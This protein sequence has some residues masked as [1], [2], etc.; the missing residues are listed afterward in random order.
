[1]SLVTPAALVRT[2]KELKDTIEAFRTLPGVTR[3]QIDVVDGRFAS[4]ASWPYT[5]PGEIN[6]M[7]AD[8]E[9]LPHLHELTYEI[10]LMCLDAGKAA[11]T[12]VALGASRLVFHAESIIN[13]AQ[14][15]ADFRMKYGC[16]TVSCDLISIG[17]AINVE[18]NLAL[19][20]PHL[21][22]VEFV[23]FM[24]IAR[25]GRQGQPFDR[26]TFDK[27]RFF[28]RL[29]PHVPIQVDGGVTLDI[30][31]ELLSIGVSNLVVGSAIIKADDP[32]SAFTEFESLK[33]PFAV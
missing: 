3:I 16:G 7:V 20:G 8:S 9:M 12:W 26:R 23:Q 4:P 24:G 27:I 32:V 17:L 21:D 13:L 2:R 5:S 10:D 1:M 28:K 14:F 31:R 30:A 11:A 25:I 33:N 6:E 15:L 22:Q 18:S 19:I 29:Y